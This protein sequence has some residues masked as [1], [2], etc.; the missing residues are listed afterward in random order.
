MRD[1]YYLIC[2][3]DCDGNMSCAIAYMYLVHC[4]VEHKNIKVLFHTGKGHGLTDNIMSQIKGD[5]K[6]LWITDAGTNDVAQCKELSEKGIDILITDHH[7]LN[8]EN[9]YA[10][11]IN[12]QMN[13]V[14]NKNGCGALVTWKFVQYCCEQNKDIF[15]THLVDLVAVAT[16]ADAMDMRSY[17][18]HA[19]AYEGLSHI[20]NPFLKLLIKDI[21]N[22]NTIGWKVAPLIN[23]VQRSDNQVLKAEILYALCGGY[24]R[25]MED[26]IKDCEKEHRNQSARVKRMFKNIID[27]YE[28]SPDHKI[29]VVVIDKKTPYTGL[30][31]N[32]L[33]DYYHKPVILVHDENGEMSGSCRG[34]GTLRSTLYDD[35]L[36]TV[37]AGHEGAFG[38]AWTNDMEHG[39]LSHIASLTL[40]EHK[41]TVSFN[42]EYYI[43]DSIFEM[44]NVNSDLW[45]QKLSKPTAYFCIPFDEIDMNIK[46]IE[47]SFEW[48]GITFIKKYPTNVEKAMTCD[49]LEIVGE[50]DA[51]YECG[52]MKKIIDIRKWE[53]N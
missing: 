21:P 24:K 35:S 10:T 34:Y 36:F 4:G 13:G 15:Y 2:D 44:S 48:N 39:V 26:I 9:P 6:F 8:G 20:T 5:C 14:Y 42:G 17:E 38:V 45:G 12:N 51:Q 19:V 41:E 37:C 11:V 50:L 25:P 16:I 7:Q 18:N 23:S 30:V 46:K 29:E 28:P 31:A 49:Y 43:D 3:S 32:R 1:K 53:F 33:R 27:E 40:P 52:E 47:M 22:P